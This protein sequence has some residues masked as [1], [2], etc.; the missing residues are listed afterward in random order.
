MRKLIISLITLSGIVFANNGKELAENNGCM[1]CHN[2]M[3][4][5][6]APAFMGT[7]RKNLRWYNSEAKKYMTKSIKNG[8][9]GKYRN[10]RDTQMPSYSYMSDKDIDTIVSWILQEYEKNIKLYPN[11]NP[12]I[13]K[14]R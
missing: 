12:N 8:S 11:G 10:F 7:A 13:K 14:G 4:K 2:I 6:L 9:K 5:K 1:G 3:G